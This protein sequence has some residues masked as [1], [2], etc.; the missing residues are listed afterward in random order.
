MLFIYINYLLLNKALLE[1]NNN[2]IFLLLNLLIINLLYSIFSFNPIYSILFLVLA[3]INF[4]LLLLLIGVKF[5]AFLIL[6]IYVGAISILLMFVLMMLNIEVVLFQTFHSFTTI[7]F[8]LSITFFLEMFILFYLK[9]LMLFYPTFI[10]INWV[11]ILHSL[12]ELLVLGIFI[13]NY[14]F[15]NLFLIGLI[16]LAALVGSVSL[17]SEK[18][19][20]KKQNLSVQLNLNDFKV[21]FFK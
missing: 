5:I 13:Y 20:V 10:Y 11:K 16:L 6:L 18:Y 14:N 4:S 8:F 17:V 15:I 7:I 3:F 12:P 2:L 19:F 1:I 9:K 21:T